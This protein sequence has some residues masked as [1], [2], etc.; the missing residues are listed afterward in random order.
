[1][2]AVGDVVKFVGS[3]GR[4]FTVAEV[5]QADA[6]TIDIRVEGSQRW[7]R[8]ESVRVVR[9][10]AEER[11]RQIKLAADLVMR[12]LEDGDESELIH[13]SAAQHEVLNDRVFKSWFQRHLQLKDCH[14][15][16]QMLSGWLNGDPVTIK[17][18]D[19]GLQVLREKLA[20]K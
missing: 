19:E 6:D 17:N 8:Q 18:L 2:I 5:D 11:D 16:R 12:H 13:L 20:T 4:E 7:Y 15:S 3:S 1:M 14:A 9:T 10:A